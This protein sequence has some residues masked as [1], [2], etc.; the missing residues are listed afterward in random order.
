M[1]R[2]RDE[3]IIKRW[4]KLAQP[5]KGA[6]AGQI[7]TYIIYTTCL[8]LLT[9]F[10]ARTIN[11]M[12][13]Q[14]WKLA[15]IN[16]GIELFLIVA[17]CIAIHFEFIFYAKTYGSVQ[18]NVSKKIYNKIISVDDKKEKEFTREKITNIALNNMANMAEFPDSVAIFFG[19]SIQVIITLVTVYVSNWLE[20][21]II[22]ALGFI[23]FFAY[24]KFNRKLGNIM[25][26]RH[27]KKDEMFKSYSKVLNGKVV[28]NEYNRS[29]IYQDELLNNV[30]KFSAEYKRYYKVHSHKAH[31]YY[32][33][34]NVVVY[35]VAAL[36]LFFVSK[37]SLEMATYLIIVPYLTS[38]TDKL[39]TL[40]D[41]TNSLELMRV[42]VDRVNL[43]LN[44]DEKQL[45]KYGAIN[46]MCEGYNLG[47]I[48]VSYDSQ[49]DAGCIKNA[50]ISFK[51]NDIN[52]IRGEKGSGKRVIFNLLR[53]N[54]MPEQG[55]ILLDNLELYDYN[56]KT[57]KN[58][59]NYCSSH[60]VFIKATI[61]E[62]LLLAND[63]FEDVQNVCVKLG[64]HQNIERYS[65][66]YNTQIDDVKS[67]GTLFL[68]GLARAIL[69]NCKIL[70]IYELPS[71]TPESFRKKI[72]K[73]LTE[74]QLDKTIIL[75][76][77][78]NSYD[79][80]A[81]LTYVVENGKIKLEKAKKIIKKD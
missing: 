33:F 67:S 48:D 19:Y 17:R 7:I 23:N 9:I 78:S 47:L 5:N 69:S 20:G 53:R 38:C 18:H 1:K 76:T 44:L 14:E 49:N 66:G 55:T 27:E 63:N 70:M 11:H 71:D 59:I 50:D 75:F 72:V 81:G 26:K 13:H 42:D 58:H 25:L 10:A 73:F 40:F 52:L 74:N 12:Y 61:K 21:I 28:I 24:F 31:I 79:E 46:K 64:V 3:N 15:F 51:M 39:N 2:K 54:I 32:A 16:L 80:I 65:E 36:M 62:N 22:T 77:H 45:I 8:F 68:I 30:D 41:R 37:G 60:P 29:Q 34:W 6:W 43:I 4:Y 35:A 56:E 57:F